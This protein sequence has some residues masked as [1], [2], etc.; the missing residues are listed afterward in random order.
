MTSLQAFLDKCKQF[1]L[2]VYPAED[3][4]S[5]TSNIEIEFPD[6]TKFN[7]YAGEDYDDLHIFVDQVKW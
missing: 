6:H 3:D 2:K 4:Y 7:L 5:S 1:H